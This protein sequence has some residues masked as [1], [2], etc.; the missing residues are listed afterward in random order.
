ME[1]VLVDWTGRS[2]QLN[3][4]MEGGKTKKLLTMSWA[5]LPTTGIG[6]MEVDTILTHVCGHFFSSSTIDGRVVLEWMDGCVNRCMY[7]EVGL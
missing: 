6:W 2:C 4:N 3:R 7:R 5:G 1:G